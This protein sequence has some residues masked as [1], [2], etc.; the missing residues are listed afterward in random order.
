MNLSTTDL[1]PISIP[2]ANVGG[3][4]VLLWSH[5]QNAFHIESFAEMLS[6][7]RR[8]YSDDR[9]MDYVPLFAGKKDDC[10]A[11]SQAARHTM[12]ARS[13]GRGAMAKISGQAN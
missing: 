2:V 5:S 7:N 10:H 1:P 13:E 9:Q 6:S 3:P 12:V 8:A 11:A 4:W